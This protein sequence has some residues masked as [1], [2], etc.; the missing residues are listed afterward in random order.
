MVTKLTA[1]FGWEAEIS[2]AYVQKRML[3]YDGKYFVIVGMFYI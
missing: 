1:D 2:F 3:Q